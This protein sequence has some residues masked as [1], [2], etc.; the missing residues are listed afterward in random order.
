M[1]KIVKELVKGNVSNNQNDKGICFGNVEYTNDIEIADKFNKYYVNSINKIIS[2]INGR[3]DRSEEVYERN[4]AVGFEKF[5][6]ITMSNL[7]KLVAKLDIKKGTDEG[8]STGILKLVMRACA[9]EYTRIINTSLT[10][11]IFP[12]E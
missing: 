2:S 8:I 6:E 5:Q 7:K 1:W 10:L 3:D 12:E 9:E 11:G 4:M